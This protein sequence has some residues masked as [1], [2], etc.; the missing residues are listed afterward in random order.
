M[1]NR[2]FKGVWI[3]KEIW[4]NTELSMLEKVVLIEISSLDNEEHCTAS[5]EYFANFCSVSIASVTR[6]IQHLID[7][8]YIKR[9][10]FDGR[11]RVLAVISLTNQNDKGPNQNDEGPNQN[12]ESPYSKCATNNIYNNI[13]NNTDNNIH[14]PAQVPADD[15]SEMDSHSYSKEE[16]RREFIGSLDSKKKRTP[17]KSL[18][19]KCM[20]E[21]FLFSKNLELQDLLIKYLDL[22]LKMRDKPIV[23]V[24]QW[25]GMLN[26]LNT[27]ST[28]VRKQKTIIEASIEHGWASFYEQSTGRHKSVAGELGAI[29]CTKY[30]GEDLSDESF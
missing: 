16:L 4:L 9:M 12:D 24:N 27:L 1:S 17:R 23:G 15:G 28:D 6:A 20:D 13:D 29:E 25:K 8:G 3:P 14:S 19:E 26:R 22:R 2:D 5:N 21:I 7:M 18:Y 10:S 30:D 11:K